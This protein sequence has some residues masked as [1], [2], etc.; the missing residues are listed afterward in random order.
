MKILIPKKFREFSPFWIIGSG[1]STI[2]L[3]GVQNYKTIRTI[4]YLWLANCFV[5]FWIHF[6]SQFV[7]D[8]RCAELWEN[9]AGK[10]LHPNVGFSKFSKF[11]FRERVESELLLSVQKR[12]IRDGLARVRFVEQMR[13]NGRAL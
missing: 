10:T 8:G 4:N 1:F 3:T 2:V 5:D 9:E 13:K 11:I 7:I 6:I 12:R